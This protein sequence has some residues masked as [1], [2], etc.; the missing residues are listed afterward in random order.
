[1]HVIFQR[2]WIQNKGQCGICGDPAD[3]PREHEIGGK[4]YSGHI[5]KSFSQN[6]VIDVAIETKSVFK[7]YVEFKICDYSGSSP[8]TQDCLNNH[9]L[10]IGGTNHSRYR[11]LNQGYHVIPLQ[12][13]EKLY[14]KECLL[15]LKYHIGMFKVL[16]ITFTVH[17]IQI[18]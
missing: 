15:Q 9:V 16:K 10:K 3:G 12:L 11:I 7:G 5:S 2:R 1:M 18:R 17:I 8:V 4:F 13:P 14:C 6:T